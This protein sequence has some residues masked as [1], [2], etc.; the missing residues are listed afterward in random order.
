MS[1]ERLRS[2]K[3]L[4]PC[5]FPLPVRSERNRLPE[6]SHRLICVPGESWDGPGGVLICSSKRISYH[7]GESA[8][9]I[10]LHANFPT[11]STDD[12]GESLVVCHATHRQKGYLSAT[13]S[14]LQFL[15]T[16]I[17]ES[18]SFC[19]KLKEVMCLKSRCRCR[20]IL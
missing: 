16:F 8:S 17:S 12:E 10:S 6:S 7:N 9:P 1:L 18:F 2:R 13:S 11:S 20:R 3:I 4:G 14:P 5:F 15:L 19:F